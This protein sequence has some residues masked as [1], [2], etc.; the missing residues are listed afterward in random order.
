M[1]WVGNE[2]DKSLAPP[3]PTKFRRPTPPKKPIEASP[4]ENAAASTV[5]GENAAVPTSESAA[6]PAI[7]ALF[8]R[9]LQASAQH[10]DLDGTSFGKGPHAAPGDYE[11]GSDALK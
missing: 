4:G 10:A 2:I 7:D 1:D 9:R 11:H 3:T 5:L 8:A 6:V